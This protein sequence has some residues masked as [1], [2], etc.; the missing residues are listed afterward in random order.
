MSIKGRNENRGNNHTE[1]DNNNNHNNYSSETSS[2]LD[3]LQLSDSFF[4]TGMFAMSSGLESIFY[5]KKITGPKDLHDLIRI[6][7][8]HQIGPADCV[9]LGNSYRALG[10]GHF[11]KIIEIDHMTYSIKL[12]EEIRNASVRSGSQLM[13]CLASFLPQ[14]KYLKLYMDA[15]ANKNAHGVY[16][17]ALALG[18]MS[19]GTSKEEA[20]LMMLY[21]FCVSIIGAALRLGIIQHLDGQGIIHSLKPSVLRAVSENIS[22][23]L[24]SMWQFAPAID[25][26]Q[27]QH[28]RLDSKMF[29][30]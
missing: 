6:Y 13:R 10:R 1:E 8:E 23:P 12:I 14:K 26:F 25:I 18:C 28:E 3:V 19:L 16:P 7:L 11:E 20:G 17:V 24:S 15:V 2:L 4:P 22:K 30:T 5:A 9:A 21:T 29:I 27:M